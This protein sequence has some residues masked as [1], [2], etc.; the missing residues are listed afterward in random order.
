LLP[1]REASRRPG[2]RN[3]ASALMIASARRVGLK[4]AATIRA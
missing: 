1:V 3:S 4:W 2:A